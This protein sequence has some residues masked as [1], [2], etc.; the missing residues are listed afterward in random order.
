MISKWKNIVVYYKISETK[1][2]ILFLA[3]MLW[4]YIKN[5]T[6][7]HT[8]ARGVTSLEIMYFAT[9]MAALRADWRTEITDVYVHI[10]RK[11]SNTIHWQ[12]IRS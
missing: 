7:Q 1:Y 10:L 6:L 9:L 12:L 4:K 5:E 2:C 3:A 8:L 11:T